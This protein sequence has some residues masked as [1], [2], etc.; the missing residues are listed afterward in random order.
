MTATAA[1]KAAKR[2]QRGDAD[3]DVFI[4]SISLVYR[5]G[6]ISSSSSLPWLVSYLM[7]RCVRINDAADVEPEVDLDLIDIKRRFNI[8]AIS[9]QK[10]ERRKR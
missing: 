5:I 1:M 7:R 4:F 10:K 8:P 2:W 9:P 6:I 3:C